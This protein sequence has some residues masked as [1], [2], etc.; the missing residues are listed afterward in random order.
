MT[1]DANVKI[2]Y[3]E[4]QPRTDQSY[5]GDGVYAEFD[6][7]QIWLYTHDGYQRT[8]EVALEPHVLCN[9]LA[10]LEALKLEAAAHGKS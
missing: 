5:L 6:G 7:W 3:V 10:Y 8:N 9:F 4:P 1:D 2:I